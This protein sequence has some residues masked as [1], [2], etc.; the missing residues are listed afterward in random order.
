MGS[1]IN[2]SSGPAHFCYIRGWEHHAKHSRR[3]ILQSRLAKSGLL[4]TS[5]KTRA[6]MSGLVKNR[7]NVS[8]LV[9][10]VGILLQHGIFLGI[11]EHSSSINC[12]RPCRGDGA[13]VFFWRFNQSKTT[14]WQLH[15]FL[16]IYFLRRPDSN[17]SFTTSASSYCLLGSNTKVRQQ[18][19]N[20]IAC[21]MSLF[22]RTNSFTNLLLKIKTTKH[23]KI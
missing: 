9:K 15:Y 22:T 17:A 21:C 23:S 18:N 12:C 6:V 8:C 2:Q 5:L 1:L 19:K 4:V 14:N 10:Y 13:Y 11:T 3:S 20:R 7:S 16:N